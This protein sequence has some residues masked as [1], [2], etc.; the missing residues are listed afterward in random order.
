MEMTGAAGTLIQ[1]RSHM[2]SRGRGGYRLV[3][4]EHIRV[5]GRARGR[6]RRGGAITA[7]ERVVVLIETRSSRPAGARL[8]G[9]GVKA[10]PPWS[11]VTVELDGSAPAAASALGRGHLVLGL[12][13]LRADD[14]VDVPR[15]EMMRSQPSY[16]RVTNRCPAR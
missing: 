2:T 14:R 3:E 13:K 1:S 16:L 12:A 15:T 6:A 9:S 7:R 10:H 4:E 11:W 5:G 8:R